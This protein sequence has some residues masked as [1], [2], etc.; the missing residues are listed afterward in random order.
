M[1]GK[2]P[3]FREHEEG[4][5]PRRRHGRGIGQ[6]RLEAVDGVPNSR[7]ASV[8]RRCFFAV[9]DGRR[10]CCRPR[11]LEAMGLCVH[12]RMVPLALFVRLAH[13]R[14]TVSRTQA[15]QERWRKWLAQMVRSMLRRC[16]R[17]R[18]GMLGDPRESSQDGQMR[19]VAG[20]GQHDDT[21]A[22]HRS[23]AALRRRIPHALPSDAA[24]SLHSSQEFLD[25]LVQMR[26]S[27]AVPLNLLPTEELPKNGAS[28]AVV[29][30]Q[31]A[32]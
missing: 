6:I 30:S 24:D 28:L 1:A 15:A 23:A 22:R 2:P 27:P 7:P 11:R 18:G 17:T 19:P 14:R 16:R 10:L 29:A 8:C 4:T 31:S 32:V 3:I 13:Y 20:A 25:R 12:A 21:E 26:L 5:H 9:R